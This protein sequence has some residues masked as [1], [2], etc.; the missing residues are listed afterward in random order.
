MEKLQKKPGPSTSIPA[1]LQ[2]LLRKLAFHSENNFGLMSQEVV[3]AVA[4]YLKFPP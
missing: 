1:D 3:E 2:A 4:S